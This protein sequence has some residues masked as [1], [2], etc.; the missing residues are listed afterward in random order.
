MSLTILFCSPQ[1]NPESEINVG[2]GG[3]YG[4]VLRSDFGDH[5]VRTDE[6]VN[7]RGAEVEGQ[8]KG[9]EIAVQERVATRQSEPAD[10]TEIGRQRE[11]RIGFGFVDPRTGEKPE[12][13]LI[14]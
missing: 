11:L 3:I 2:C 14:V 8:P 1:R 13:D 6:E 9:F 4:N 10:R 5:V 7:P 12:A